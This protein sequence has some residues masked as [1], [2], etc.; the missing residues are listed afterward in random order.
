MFLVGVFLLLALGKTQAEEL[1]NT[2][3]YL[4]EGANYGTGFFVQGKDY[5]LVTA[6]H[7]ATYL[8]PL[9]PAVVRGENDSGIKFTLADLVGTSGT[10]LDWET[11][12]DSD[13]AVLRVQSQGDLW[14]KLKPRFISLDWFERKLGAPIRERPVTVMGF[15]LQLGTK[16]YFSPG[17]S[18]AKTSSG[19]QTLYSSIIKKEATFYALDKPSI[20]GF[21]GGPAYL[22]PTPYTIGSKTF[23]PAGPNPTP[24]FVG[25]VH[26]LVSDKNGNGFALIVPS[27]FI[28]DVI[29]KADAKTGTSNKNR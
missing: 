11:H 8:K 19:L 5:Y 23:F 26:G 3:V 7:V 24:L 16:G 12:T 29:L 9:S 28:V 20:A 15:P 17:T 22:L 27:K 18:E 13:V 25:L 4:S 2:V 1:S 14:E 6:E 10:T 21:S